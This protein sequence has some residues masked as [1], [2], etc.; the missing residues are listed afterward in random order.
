MIGKSNI[1]VSTLRAIENV[2]GPHPETSPDPSMRSWNAVVYRKQN[3]GKNS[4]NRKAVLPMEAL[5]FL[6]AGVA[7]AKRYIDHLTNERG[8]LR[9]D[10]VNYKTLA[11]IAPDVKC[12]IVGMG[13]DLHSSR[14]NRWHAVSDYR[15]GHDLTGMRL[16][17]DLDPALAEC[18][19]G[20][21]LSVTRSGVDQLAVIDRKLRWAGKDNSVHR[22]VVRWMGVADGPNGIPCVVA[23]ARLQKSRAE[24]ETVRGLVSADANKSELR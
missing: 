7:N 16:D 9:T 2:V 15:Q 10:D 12:H 19:G 8:S 24:V 18:F 22:A 3:S 6:D 14:F 1:T 17:E 20:D 23:L 21:C 4:D 13:A 11:D 5:A